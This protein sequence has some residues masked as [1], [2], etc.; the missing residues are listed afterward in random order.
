VHLV[1]RDDDLAD[2]RRL[3]RYRT[4]LDTLDGRRV[5]TG[6]PGRESSR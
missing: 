2:V 6:Q 3:P 4:W 1:E 5:E